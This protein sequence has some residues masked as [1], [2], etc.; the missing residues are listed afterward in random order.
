[1]GYPTRT[2]LKLKSRSSVTYIGNFRIIVKFYTEHGCDIG[3]NLKGLT[4][5][6]NGKWILL[7]FKI[8]ISFGW[9]PT[10]QQPP[11]YLETTPVTKC[12]YLCLLCSSYP[13]YEQWLKLD[14]QLYVL[15]IHADVCICCYRQAYWIKFSR[16]KC[17]FDLFHNWRNALYR[18]KFITW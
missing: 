15:Y 14:L 1:M 10:L 18:F 9:Y 3:Q 17:N 6:Y 16:C 13:W 8:K 7:R 4:N 2:R 5:W 12:Y 11:V